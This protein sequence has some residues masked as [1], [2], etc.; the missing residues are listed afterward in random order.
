MAQLAGFKESG[1]RKIADR[2]GYTGPM[3]GFQAYLQENP[4]KQQM[5]NSYV[6]KAMLMASG[7]YVR[8]FQE[9]GFALPPGFDSQTYLASNPDVLQGISRGEF[10]SAEDHFK[11]FG[12][13]ENRFGSVG[14][15]QQFLQA[16]DQ[17]GTTTPNIPGV[18]ADQG[19]SAGAAA[20]YIQ[21]NPDL[22]QD[23]LSK[24]IDVTPG[25]RANSQKVIEY[26]LQHYLSTGY[27]EGRPLGI[28]Q[29]AQPVFD[30]RDTVTQPPEDT[31]TPPTDT[32]T[33]PTDDRDTVT[34]TPPADTITTAPD[35]N[36]GFTPEQ[37]HRR[38]F[39]AST[40]E[41]QEA[42]NARFPFY[43]LPVGPT[44][45]GAPAVDT[46]QPTTGTDTQP[47]TGTDTQPPAPPPGSV[48]GSTYIAN[49]PDIAQ[50]I[51]G[52]ETFGIDP[53]TLQGLSEEEKNQR[54][55]QAHFN[56]FGN[57]E[58]INPVTGLSNTPSNFDGVS[59]Q[60][61][62]DYLDQYPDL[63]EAFGPNND[64][65][66]LAKARAHYAD[67]GRRE[68]AEGGRP[69]LIQFDLTPA[70]LEAFRYS[71]DAYE[72]LT[73][74]EL[75]R[76]YIQIGG[77]SGATNFDRNAQIL[78]N[79]ELAIYRD[80][81][82]D[83]ANL[84][85]F[86]LRQHFIQFGRQEMLQGTRPKIDALI[87]DPSQYAGL[88]SIQDI[89]ASRLETP[90]L[91]GDTK[92]TATTI[93][94]PGGTVP[95]KTDIATTTGQVTGDRKATFK[96]AGQASVATAA[97]PPSVT[98]SVTDTTKTAT[99]VRTVTD[100]TTGATKTLTQ[101]KPDT[102][103]Q[104]GTQVAGLK[105]DTG[106][107][108]LATEATRLL[109]EP[110]LITPAAK[111]E[112]AAEFVESIV[113]Q[114]ANPSA[115]ATVAGQLA[116]LLGDFDVS[117]PPSWAAGAMR[118]ATAEMVRRGM[119]ASSI[120]GQAIV[121]AAMEAALPIAQ[122]DAQIQAQF[123]GQNLSNR[124]QMALFYAQQRASFIG[125]EFDQTFQSRVTNAARI[126]DIADKNFTAQQQ[127][128]LENS[129]AANTMNLQNLSNKQALTMA[130][131]SSLA[132]IDIAN[133]S[134]RQQTAVLEA[135]AFLQRDMSELSNDQQT[136]L[137]NAQ[138]RIQSMFTD[139]AADNARKQFNASTDAQ[140]D[141]FFANLATQT[142][143]FNNAQKNAIAQ[144]NSGQQNT[145][146]RFNA[147]IGNQR[148]QFNQA[149]RLVIDQANAVWRRS[150]ATA[151]TAAINRVNELNAS[152]LLDISDTAY[153]DLW[154][155]YSDVI[156]YAY[157]AAENQLDR[158]ASLAEANLNAETRKQIADEEARTAAGSAI[159]G[160]IG[161]LG[162]AFLTRGT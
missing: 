65:A 131:A 1:M 34:T 119:G 47:T 130:E 16:V 81:N 143:Q 151:D 58:N 135:Q 87:P 112:A 111:K 98:P 24:G 125:Q 82:P 157:R 51:A 88:T 162:A 71:N 74:T 159:G 93:A 105:A 43:Q 133:L 154:Q 27:K 132:Q 13:G 152:A 126:S 77:A 40:P 69:R 22:V 141:Q 95:A 2:M 145:I 117:N 23:A 108:Q 89:A 84:S 3:T 147:E 52:G 156:E 55:A 4:D 7:G 35:P 8:K 161:T 142:S 114:S 30:A 103:L 148:D 15:P 102:A 83:L 101:A 121:Q 113:A 70:Q 29:E 50:A 149:N 36:E 116:N 49:R 90:R 86:E 10:A 11:K 146:N 160:L 66:T 48:V 137:F 78:N 136:R 120:A 115:S 28:G 106:T 45:T 14:V 54:L 138:Q 140:T 60:V 57:Q 31:T 128:V 44:D 41:E 92:L 155:Q 94:G 72:N 19:I 6:N 85:D 100:A 5:M 79:A 9:G 158:A 129:R 110:E 38:N 64:P 96:T 127:V 118:A 18:R 153:N 17:G 37:I 12:G 97:P 75:R 63:R 104:I 123:E 109:G 32:T 68:I 91:A 39:Y 107:A 99:D 42:I 124:Q 139:A 46:T 144:F 20:S 134:N 67:F 21:A 150:I 53:A 33:P 56:A 76:T 62:I 61:I 80:N 25:G 73:P 59:D 26:A 122:A